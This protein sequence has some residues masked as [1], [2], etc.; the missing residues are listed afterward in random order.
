MNYTFKILNNWNSS[1]KELCEE[2]FKQS[3]NNKG[4][5][6]NIQMVTHNSPDFYVIL[7]GLLTDKLPCEPNKII[8]LQME[9]P[10]RLCIDDND[11]RTFYYNGE[12]GK[13]ESRNL[14]QNNKFKPNNIWLKENYE[15]F[16][17][18]LLPN[19][20]QG[21][22]WHLKCDYN[23]LINNS[24]VKTK[25][26]SSIISNLN[27]LPGHQK[28]NKFLFYL[29]N[30][31]FNI[32]MFGKQFKTKKYANLTLYNTLKNYKGE[33]PKW[34]CENAL[35]PYKYTFNSENC[36]EI[37]YYTEKVNNAILCEC[38]LFY[39]GCPNL[40]DY[41][42]PNAFIRLDLD[43]PKESLK[44]IEDAIKN[45]EWEKRIDI[46]RKEKLKILNELQLF[47]TIENIINTNK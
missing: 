39:W 17:Y 29:D 28:R 45:N 46:I 19:H 15:F 21:I 13:M 12:N 2:F 27:Y 36:N 16:H 26:M 18:K 1:Q 9:P 34:S 20:R 8:L 6:N 44:I 10:F 24:F 22:Q 7:N 4:K 37:N 25:I 5:W 30:A 38:L 14:D 40:E 23:F 3:Q 33:L 32:D 31:N 42:D 11:P 35:M 47:P 43:K 41:I